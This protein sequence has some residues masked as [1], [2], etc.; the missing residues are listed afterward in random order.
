MQ[1]LGKLF[2]AN[3]KGL[4]QIFALALYLYFLLF[5]ECGY[6]KQNMKFIF[7]HFHE[8][9][10]LKKMLLTTEAKVIEHHL[11]TISRFFR[12]RLKTFRKL[13]NRKALYWAD[14]VVQPVVVPALV[15]KTTLVVGVVDFVD[16]ADGVEVGSGIE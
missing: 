7:S 2:G 11:C 16:V 10:I 9:L 4:I 8:I 12:K 6:C 1:K 14:V 15:V 5:Q 13:N 3:D